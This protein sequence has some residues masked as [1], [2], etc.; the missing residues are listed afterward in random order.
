MTV[1]REGNQEGAFDGEVIVF[2]GKLGISH[3]EAAA[4]TS[5]IGWREESGVTKKTTLL[6]IGVQDKKKLA[7]YE[8]S[9]KQRKA[10]KLIEQNFP[11]RI[12]SEKQFKEL[13]IL[14]NTNH[15]YFRQLSLF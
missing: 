8:K 7:G 12:L 4:I 6:V 3:R 2:T 14:T 13:A 15:N 9:S 5:A 1:R 10:E 11:I